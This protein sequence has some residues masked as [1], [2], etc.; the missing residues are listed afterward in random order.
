MSLETALNDLRTGWTE[1]LGEIESAEGY[2]EDT[3]RTEM[4]KIAKG[5]YDYR[6]VHGDLN[7]AIR[8][9]IQ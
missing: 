5:W 3:Y 4:N 7:D 2:E 8:E 1:Y 6:N 9:K